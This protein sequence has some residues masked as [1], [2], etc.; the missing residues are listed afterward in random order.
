[1]RLERTA[2]LLIV[3]TA[4]IGVALAQAAPPGSINYQ[5]VLRDGDDKPLDGIYDMVFRFYR[6]PTQVSIPP[7]YAEEHKAVQGGS[8]EVDGGLFT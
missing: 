4:S 3:L 6:T 2:L 8:V 5:G 1:M 7:L